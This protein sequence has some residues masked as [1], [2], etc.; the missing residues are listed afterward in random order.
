MSRRKSE[1]SEEEKWSINSTNEGGVD[2]QTAN[3]ESRKQLTSLNSPAGLSSKSWEKIW[4]T[5][6]INSTTSFANTCGRKGDG[7]KCDTSSSEC[8]TIARTKHNVCRSL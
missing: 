4:N 5:Y 1:L 6:G 3:A 8:Q 2:T 7:G